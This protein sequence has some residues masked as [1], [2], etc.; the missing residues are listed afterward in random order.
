MREILFRGKQAD[1][2]DWAFGYLF[3]D[4]LI[5][6][7]RTFVGG[8]VVTDAKDTTSDRY[9]IRIAFYEVDP[10]TIDQYTG[11]TDK[12]GVKIF[13]GDILLT[14]NPNCK[15]WYVDYKPTAFCAN[16]S[17]VNYSCILDEFVSGFEAEVIG[18][19]HDNPE[20]LSKEDT[21]C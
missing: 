6:R 10:A 4:G 8:L 19:I 5:D 20:L 7:K 21:K 2:G 16:Q 15:I 14:T 11:L 1:N 3:D 18:N 9:E 12:N 17:N 13:E